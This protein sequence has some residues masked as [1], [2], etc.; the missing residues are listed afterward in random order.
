MEN[1]VEDII[2][3]PYAHGDGNHNGT[4][5]ATDL[6]QRSE[7]EPQPEPLRVPVQH[8]EFGDVQDVADLQGQPPVQPPV[9]QLQPPFLFYNG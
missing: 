5:V 1:K 6:T 2:P 7:P 8:A 4:P 9:Q 3:T